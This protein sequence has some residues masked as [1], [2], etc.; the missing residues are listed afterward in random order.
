MPR[1]RLL[2]LALL[3]LTS[4]GTAQAEGFSATI[5]YEGVQPKSNNGVIAG[6][7]ATVDDAW[8]YTGSFAYH[9]NDNWSADLWTGLDGF[10]HKVDLDGL[11]TVATLSHR[12]TAIGVN[13]HFNADGKVRPYVGLGYNWVTVS[14][15]TGVGALTGVPLDVDNDDGLTYTAGID[16][17]VTDNVFIRG[18]VRKL[19]F[20]SDVF[21]GGA[22]AGTAEV[23]PLVWGISAGIK[24]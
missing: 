1:I 6:A 5:G 19:S 8:S 23:D 13:Y 9:F 17:D 4:I 21:A 15:E 24:F 12:P 2:A 10:D 7:D 16:F 14:D 3:G 18:S 20:E 22:L 11:G